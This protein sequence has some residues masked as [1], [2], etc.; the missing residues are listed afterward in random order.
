M[1]LYQILKFVF[2]AVFLTHFITFPSSYKDWSQHSPHWGKNNC[3]TLCW[4]TELTTV[5]DRLLIQKM[6]PPYPSTKL[7]NLLK[8]TFH[9]QLK[10]LQQIISCGVFFKFHSRFLHQTKF[11]C[12]SLLQLFFGGFTSSTKANFDYDLH[13]R[14]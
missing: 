1:T 13:I 14:Q 2:N 4:D 12:S 8:N 5:T 7:A 6:T 9:Q 10:S 3:M 11:H